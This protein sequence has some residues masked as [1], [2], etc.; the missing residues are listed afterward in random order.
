MP[1]LA[2]RIGCDR[3]KDLV[4]RLGKR[5]ID[6][7]KSAHIIDYFHFLDIYLRRDDDVLVLIPLDIVIVNRTG[8]HVDTV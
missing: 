3:H 8:C 4:A 7:D 2:T 1:I 5:I 6:R